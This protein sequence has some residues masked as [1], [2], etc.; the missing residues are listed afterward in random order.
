[1]VEMPYLRTTLYDSTIFCESPRMLRP[2]HHRPPARQRP[3]GAWQVVEVWPRRRRLEI[4]RA[5][6]GAAHRSSRT[7]QGDARLRGGVDDR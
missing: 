5:L 4:P 3:G 2:P 6:P 7:L 1:M